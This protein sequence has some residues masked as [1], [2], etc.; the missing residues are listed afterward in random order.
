MPLPTLI[1]DMENNLYFNAKYILN[2]I[3]Y[4]P[5]KDIMEVLR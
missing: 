3:K 2:C 5:N 4:E 1:V